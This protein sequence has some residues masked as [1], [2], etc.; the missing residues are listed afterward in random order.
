MADDL[1]DDEL[2][3]GGLD[4]YSEG[5]DDDADSGYDL[6]PEPVDVPVLPDNLSPAEE[7]RTIRDAVRRQV[8]QERIAADARDEAEEA[9]D[10]EEEEGPSSVTAITDDD[11]DDL[12]GLDNSDVM[13]DDDEDSS[14]F[15]DI[16]SVSAEDMDDIT[17]VSTDDVRGSA[18]RRRRPPR[19]IIRRQPSGETF[20]GVGRVGY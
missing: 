2:D 7:E 16:T 6:P 19:K 9:D 18:P 20:G 15:S 4:P 8:R 3:D 11:W 10:E 1:R 14:D 5:G 12:T 17:G 13:G